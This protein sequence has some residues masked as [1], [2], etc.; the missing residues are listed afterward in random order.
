VLRIFGPKEENVKEHKP[1]FDSECSELLDQ[2]KQAKLQWLKN[3][4]QT[5]GDNLTYVRR[6]TNTIYSKKREHLKEK[7][8]SLKQTVRTKI[9]QTYIEVYMN[10]ER[11]P[12]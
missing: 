4:S 9:S 3:S 5:S 10:L 7:S 1:R 12:T 11:L 2:S 8:M 6:Q